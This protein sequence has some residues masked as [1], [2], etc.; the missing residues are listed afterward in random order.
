VAGYSDG[1]IHRPLAIGAKVRFPSVKSYVVAKQ[2][3]LDLITAASGEDTVEGGVKRACVRQPEVG[4]ELAGGAVEKIEG[5][6]TLVMT[7][8]DEV[9]YPTRNKTDLVQR[10]REIYLI[11]R[12]MD[13]A[14]REYVMTTDMVIQPEVYRSTLSEMS[15]SQP[16]DV[17]AAFVA[18]RLISRM[19]GLTVFRDKSKLK[20]LLTGSVLLDDVNEP[21]LNLNDFVSE[22]KISN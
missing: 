5:A 12:M 13:F 4:G 17:H 20:L 6:Y 2:D 7:D 18:C 22:H 10:E 14:R 1:V 15:D 19:Q 11:L 8:L 16:E 9:T 3:L 21:S